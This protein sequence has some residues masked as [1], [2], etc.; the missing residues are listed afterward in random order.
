VTLLVVDAS[1]AVK[2]LLPDRAD[3]A[4]SEQALALL[5]GIRKGT[6]ELIQPPHWLAEVAAVL[7]RLSPDTI[8]DDV[9]DLYA[10]ELPVLDTPEMYLTACELARSLGH[11][12][13]DTLYHAV[14]L[15]VKDTSLVTA[16]EHYY[17]KASVRGSIVLLNSFSLPG[18]EA[19]KS[20]ER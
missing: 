5:F 4:D 2:W 8:D 19:A 14:A 9:G 10:L 1:V 15:E 17:R 11:H 3:E 20:V 6:V 13:F 18:G 12:L 16:D 7:A